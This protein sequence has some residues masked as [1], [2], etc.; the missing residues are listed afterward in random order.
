MTLKFNGFKAKRNFHT[1]LNFVLF[2]KYEMHENKYRTKICDF[3]VACTP[4]LSLCSQ[5]GFTHEKIQNTEFHWCRA[6]FEH[7]F[8]L[9]SPI[10]LPSLADGRKRKFVE[11]KTQKC[12]ALACFAIAIADIFVQNLMVGFFNSHCYSRYITTADMYWI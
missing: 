3:T 11:R 10:F 6:V 1:I 8:S 7:F 4:I 9:N 12:R 5:H 2:Q